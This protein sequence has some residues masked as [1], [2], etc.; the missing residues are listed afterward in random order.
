ME[1][2][3]NVRAIAIVAHRFFVRDTPAAH[4]FVR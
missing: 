3:A 4:L 2:D 1:N